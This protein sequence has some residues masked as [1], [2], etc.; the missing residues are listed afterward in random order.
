MESFRGY[1]LLPVAEDD[2]YSFLIIQSRDSNCQTPD[3]LAE[4]GQRCTAVS[5]LVPQG[6]P[7]CLNKLLLHITKSLQPEVDYIMKRCP[8][9][10]ACVASKEQQTGLTVW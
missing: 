3:Y 4:M 1:R 10:K 5:K 6:N 2:Y 7:Y 9:S 8:D